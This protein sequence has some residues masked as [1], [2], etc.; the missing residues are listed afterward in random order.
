MTQAGRPLAAAP[1]SD[2]GTVALV[3]ELSICA[4]IADIVERHAEGRQ[5]ER[6]HLDIGHLR[7]VIPET[8]EYSWDIVVAD[9]DLAGS[10]LVVDYIP[11]VISCRECGA[12]T[13]LADPLFRCGCGSIDID[14][15]SG[16]ELL[17][18]SLELTGG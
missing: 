12:V 9:T 14:V 8:L 10:R 5:V 6:V 3:H 4:S 7:Q 16:Q 17:I 13:E 18:R 11:A 2:R 1:P 15:T